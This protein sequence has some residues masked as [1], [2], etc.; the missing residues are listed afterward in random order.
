MIRHGSGAD[1]H[2][3]P[4][5]PGFWVAEAHRL[6]RA[7]ELCWTADEAVRER[8]GQYL[9]PFVERA[10]IDREVLAEKEL[11]LLYFYL[12][13]LAIEDLAIGVAL[14][15]DPESLLRPR[16]P[17]RLGDLMT[18]CGVD[19]SEP[20]RRLV[21]QFDAFYGWSKRFAAPRMRLS[22]QELMSLKLASA[23]PDAVTPT[24]KRELERLF[25]ALHGRIPPP[26]KNGPGADT[27]AN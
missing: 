14:I 18:E 17:S 12:A 15:Q 4:E 22:P 16:S 8:L 23:G 11:N 24:D 27:D 7:A 5:D 10:V 2:A 21:A 19:L 26:G 13:C 6:N 20:Q 25:E 3:M 1:D 9:E